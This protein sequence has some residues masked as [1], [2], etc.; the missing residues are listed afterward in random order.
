MKI[1][2]DQ[3]LEILI[4]SGCRPNSL[5]HSLIVAGITRAICEDLKANVRIDTDLAVCGAV[6]HDVTKTR[7]IETGEHHDVTGGEYIRAL[8]F[9][10]IAR[11]IE[12]HVR[13]NNFSKS[14]PLTEEEIVH[15]AD[16][17]VKHSEIVSIDD[18]IKDLII[19]YGSTPE[20]ADEIAGRIH[21]LKELEMKIESQMKTGISGAI[22]KIK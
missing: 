9:E 7:S 2:P 5:S 11:I 13:L 15:Y 20:R 16:K 14:E 21:F 6:L 18:R 3:A 4:E 22:A 10:K 17:R 19:R 12:A 1:T 8:G